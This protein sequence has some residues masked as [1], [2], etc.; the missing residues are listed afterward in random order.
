MGGTVINLAAVRD[1]ALAEIHLKNKPTFTR[2]REREKERDRGQLL[3]WKLGKYF[4]EAYVRSDRNS[5][6]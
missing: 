6:K 2:K 3:P 1:S 5:G 4:V